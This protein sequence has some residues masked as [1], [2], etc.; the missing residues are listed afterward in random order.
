M[1]SSRKQSFVILLVLTTLIL[2]LTIPFASAQ[3]DVF[4]QTLEG[5][6]KL[7]DNKPM[8]FAILFFLF[9]FLLYGIFAIGLSRSKAF[10]PEGK[11]T[12]TGKTICLT[13]SG[14][15]VLSVFFVAG[16]G[17][18]LIRAR[19]IAHQFN[20]F[21][22]VILSVL[23]AAIFRYIFD[24]QEINGVN[25]RNIMTIFGLALALQM[26]GS[27]GGRP[28]FTGLGTTLFVILAIY[29][30]LKMFAGGREEDEMHYN[31]R[32]AIPRDY[33]NRTDE[34][35]NEVRERVRRDLN[36]MI[37]SS[38]NEMHTIHQRLHGESEEVMNNTREL[39]RNT[40]ELIERNE[41]LSQRMTARSSAEIN[42]QQ[43]Q[44]LR[45]NV[46]DI[47]R[48]VNVFT[49]QVHHTMNERDTVINN[50]VN[51]FNQEV[52]QG[53]REGI[54]R[55]EDRLEVAI[56]EGLNYIHNKSHELNTSLITRYEEQHH[57]Y[58]QLLNDTEDLDRR[59]RE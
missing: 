1:H 25:M 5:V 18:V 39:E 13:M 44:R 23:I 57:T 29:A 24:S 30:I 16:P 7:M 21:F 38:M 4:S 36:P 49:Q 58:D 35:R 17:Q 15:V 45:T 11:L 28:L 32:G 37:E 10:S 52:G 56:N 22:A 41:Q 55:T 51:Q 3:Q 53:T 20:I 47:I 50:G 19:E 2:L 34:E 33:N 42:I 8:M 40:Q 43:L 26:F 46:R 6:H 14:I 54:T 48:R 12:K 31:I 9:Y 59:T 27:I